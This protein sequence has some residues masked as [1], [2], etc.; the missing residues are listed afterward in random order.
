MLRNCC[1][2]FVLTISVFLGMPKNV[3][4]CQ[5]LLQTIV[6]YMRSISVRSVLM[7]SSITRIWKFTMQP[8][9]PLCLLICLM[10]WKMAVISTEEVS[11]SVRP[12]WMPIV[13]SS[14][15]L[16]CVRLVLLVTTWPLLKLVRSTHF[17]ESTIVR[18]TPVL[19]Y[20][21]PAKTTSN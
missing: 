7:I 10:L 2:W 15:P 11:Y 5:P 9:E 13:L 6:L 12:L 19:F 4:N 16:T 3:T 1:V 8:L 21:K 18:F 14:S 17:K 20:A